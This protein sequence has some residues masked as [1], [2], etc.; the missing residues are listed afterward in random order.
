[1]CNKITKISTQNR[2]QWIGICNHG[3]AHIF[4]R[5]SK[6]YL[7]IEELEVLRSKALAGMLPVERIG[8]EYLFWLNR[9]ALKLSEDEYH[10]IQELFAFA[11]EEKQP[12]LLQ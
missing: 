8:D 2:F 3:S 10:E 1:M 11:S 7:P 6:I 4:W 5:T 12:P 9:V